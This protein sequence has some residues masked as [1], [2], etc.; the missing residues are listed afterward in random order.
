ML[1]HNLFLH[2]NSIKVQL[3]HAYFANKKTSTIFQF[4][5]GTIKTVLGKLAK[6]WS[7]ISIP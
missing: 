7:E 5:K 3:K 1:S 2:F 4:H 6:A